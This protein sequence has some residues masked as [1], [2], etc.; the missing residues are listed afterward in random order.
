V[1]V[2]LLTVGGEAQASDEEEIGAAAAIV[3]FGAVDLSFSVRA[4]VL[5]AND[6]DAQFGYSLAQSIATVP[7]AVALNGA[8]LALMHD[9]D[10]PEAFL[11]LHIPAT[12]TTAL[13]VH[14]LWSL[15]TPD[16]DQRLTFLA[17]TA[18]GVNTMWTS[19]ML[20]TATAGRNRFDDDAAIPG[21]Y[22]ILTTV[23]GVAIGVHQALETDRFTAGWIGIAGWSGLL[24]LHGLLFSTGVIGDDD[25]YELGQERRAPLAVSDLGIA[26]TSLGAPVEGAPETPGLVVSGAF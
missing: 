25:D 16:E 19:F 17:S 18:I 22:E 12:M 8:M 26:P 6:G 4:I 2:A 7:Q 9:H 21:V 3:A 13:A 14:G 10:A 15:A 5:A 23:P 24:S 11:A 1:L 20:G